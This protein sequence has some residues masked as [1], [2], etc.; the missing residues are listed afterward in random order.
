MF[1]DSWWLIVGM[2]KTQAVSVCKWNTWLACWR[3]KHLT[4]LF[5]NE[6]PDWPVCELVMASKPCL[7]AYERN[8][9]FYACCQ[10]WYV[11]RFTV[12]QKPALLPIETHAC[13]L[14]I[15]T[16]VWPVINWTT[17]LTWYQVKHMPVLLPI[18]TH[19]CLLPIET[20][21]CLLPIETHACLLPIETYACLVANWNTCL[22]VT[23]WNTCLS[24]TNWNTS[25]PCHQFKNR[26]NLLAKI[27]K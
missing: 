7:F 21:A 25:L 9:V 20:H 18:E 6:T 17:S 5:A 15:E 14:P 13:L 10:N 24:V 23:N 22:S 12:Q 26:P 16:Q 11:V 4:G 2:W 8:I 1:T 19:A 27:C 3:M